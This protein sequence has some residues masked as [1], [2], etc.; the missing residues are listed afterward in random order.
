VL[1]ASVTARRLKVLDQC[2]R[3][4]DVIEAE[5]QRDVPPHLLKLLG[6]SS[7]VAHSRLRRRGRASQTPYV[8][9][10]RQS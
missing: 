7:Q 6:Q 1:R 5:M 4:M 9:T 10:H 2:D 3:A 8:A